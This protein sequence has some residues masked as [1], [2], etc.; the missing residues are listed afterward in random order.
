MSETI[1]AIATP[2]GKGGVA[3]IR[4]SGDNAYDCLKCVFRKENMEARKMYY[5]VKIILYKHLERLLEILQ[6]YFME[7]RP[8]TSYFFYVIYCGLFRI[9]KII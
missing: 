9:R 6:I 4:I 1:A 3:I 8:N 5:G 7:Y 2:A